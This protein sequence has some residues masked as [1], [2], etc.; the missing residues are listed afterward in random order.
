M[1]KDW[2][3]NWIKDN[4]SIHVM[5]KENR[6]FT[7]AIV[8]GCLPI[9]LGVALGLKINN[10]KDKVYVFCGDMTSQTGIFHE[11]FKYAVNHKLPIKFIIENNFLSTNTDTAEVWGVSRDDLENFFEMQKTKYPNYFDYITYERVFPHYGTGRFI[12][13]LWEK[14]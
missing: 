1:E 9:A 8:G 2:L 14:K 13:K 5:N 12:T 4:K 6:I 3:L 10:S 7:S 11:C